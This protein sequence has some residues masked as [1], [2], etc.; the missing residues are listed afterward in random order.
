MDPLEEYLAKKQQPAADPLEAYL[1]K[2]AA[3]AAPQGPDR[4]FSDRASFALHH[5]LDSLNEEAQI[6]GTHVS[7]A[8]DTASF[9]LYRKLR[10]AAENAIDP[11]A[12]AQAENVEQ[13]IN[14]RHPFAAGVSSAGGYFIPYGG[15][16]ML[17]GSGANL[18]GRAAA[19]VPAAV[20]R[21]LTSR[22]VAGAIVGG[23]TAAAGQAA[24]DVSNGAPLDA[25]EGKRA[26]HAAEV[27]AGLG[28]GAGAIGATG[29]RVAGA[30]RNPKTLV[31][32]T[33]ADVEAAGGR[34]HPVGE[35]VSGG[36]YETPEMQALPE[37]KEGYNQL[38]YEEGQRITAHNDAKL[39]NARSDYG[40]QI[41]QHL[42]ANGDNIHFVVDTHNLLDR[43]AEENS[44]NG[45]TGDPHLANAIDKTR[46]MLTKEIAPRQALSPLVHT[47]RP[48]PDSV[49]PGF[50]GTGAVDEFGAPVT[51]P[52]AKGHKTVGGKTNPGGRQPSMAYAKTEAAGPPQLPVEMTGN[53]A[54]QP[55][56]SEEWPAVTVPDLIK[57]KRIVDGL[58]EHGMPATP[59]NRPYR[60]I[61]G[62]LARELEA[63]DPNIAQLNKRYAGTMSD[64]ERSNDVIYGSD[65]AETPTRAAKERRAAGFLGRIGDDTQAGTIAAPQLRELADADPV[66][67]KAFERVKAKKA[68]ERLRYGYPE[69]STNIEKAGHSFVRQNLDA[70]KARIALPIAEA[71]GRIGPSPLSMMYLPEAVRRAQEAKRRLEKR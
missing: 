32:R 11:Q 42:A 46:Q 16:A 19:R 4:S 14:E 49:P 69:I 34:I 66:Y 39:K 50:A 18:L 29:S 64:L 40:Q 8:L 6:V 9:G 56:Q 59:E 41:G 21:V 7:N 44:I 1:A 22:P 33:I 26:L 35:P 20:G 3:P 38:A 47:P 63:V 68:Q 23:T 5:P 43:L 17:A 71:A 55:L 70:A 60:M 37:G 2:K 28:F 15:P 48:P 52:G 13:G 45:V 54:R 30:I 24:Q 62:S 31:G 51:E 10:H 27:G 67:A 36:V 61:A 57:T 58:A 25:E 65:R 53:S 12:T